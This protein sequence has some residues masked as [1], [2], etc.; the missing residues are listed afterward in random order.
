MG[1]HD[2]SKVNPVG[3]V[4]QLIRG[5]YRASRHKSTKLDRLCAWCAQWMVKEVVIP[6]KPNHKLLRRTPAAISLFIGTVTQGLNILS[7]V[8]LAALGTPM[9]CMQETSCRGGELCS[10]VCGGAA[11]PHPMLWCRLS[12]DVQ[13]HAL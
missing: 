10:R 7:E 4:L 8:P 9:C 1:V 3:R 6:C 12:Q 2:I 11:K 5:R 13:H